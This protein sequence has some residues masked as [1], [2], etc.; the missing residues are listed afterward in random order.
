MPNDLLTEAL[1]EAYASAPAD[2]IPLHTLELDHSTFTEAIR[3]VRNYEDVATW[4]AFGDADVDAALAAL[5]DSAADPNPL[6]MVGLVARLEEDAPRDPGQMV[7][8]IALGFNLDLPNVNTG[9]SPTLTL[10]MDNV[11]RELITYLD[12]ALATIEPIVVRY[13]T[14]LS[15]DVSGP[16]SATHEYTLNQITITPAVITAQA[17]LLDIGNRQFPN[18][19]HTTDRFPAQSY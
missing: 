7:T 19:H 14:Y 16:Q 6:D 10:T 17:R 1:Q 13:R 5:D 11:G 15:T 3:V 8:W 9:A 12:L 18:I 2:A 4:Q